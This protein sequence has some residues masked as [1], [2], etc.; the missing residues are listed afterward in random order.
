M[1]VL[2]LALAALG[3]CEGSSGEPLPEP[4][5]GSQVKVD[6]VGY[7]PNAAKLAVVSGELAEDGFRL[8]DQATGKTVLKGKLS[9]SA[10]DNASGDRVRTADFS[11]WT[12]PGTYVI[13]ANSG[14]SSHPF[15]IGA[16]VYRKLWTDNGRSFTLHRAGAA[17]DDPV[18]GLAHAA[19]HVQDQAAYMFTGDEFHPQDSQL[20]VS[21]GWYDAGDYGKYTPTAAVST[22]N[23]LLAY[24]WNPD[25]FA[26]GQWRIPEALVASG[27]AG[28]L[29][30]VLQEAKV[31]LDWLLKMQRPDGAVYL[32]VA[33]RQW[34][35][36]VKPE[37]D[38]SDRYVFGLSTYGTGQFAGVTA[39]AARVYQP[40]NA[41]YAA[42]LLAHA[43]LAQQYLLAHPEPQFQLAEGQDQG[44]GPYRKDTDQE[45]RFWATAELLRTTGAADYAKQLQ[46]S[47]AKL[48]GATPQDASW[49]NTMLWGQWA[50]ANSPQAEAGLRE[51]AK[52][53]IGAF[54]QQLLHTVQQDGYRAALRADEYGWGS[55]R[56]LAA[57]AQALLMAAALQP[58]AALEEAAASQLHYLLGAN[59]LG[60]SFVTGAGAVPP[61]H[62]HSRIMASTGTYVPGVLVGGPNRDGGDAVVN[63]LMKNAAVP[64]PPAK[65]YADDVESFS[66][67]EYAIDYSSALFF[68][69]S[70]VQP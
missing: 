62:P 69:L 24:E 23:L 49:M 31:E 47:F 52:A 40:F 43:K 27:W 11:K 50:L 64:L 34:P 3:G 1:S 41:A 29:P 16:D 12:Q 22:A 32:K 55:N 58:D 38:V 57:K 45:E 18:S 44:S 25:K 6:Q 14:G 59:A 37:E 51:Q 10:E 21:G 61:L 66:T 39:L 17:M 33:G 8:V 36:Y 68:L 60:R 67:N 19:G 4:P 54:G 9:K 35:G 15:A 42:E 56:A 7:L 70:H 13:K 53:A 5:A 30:D 46:S 2:A 48:A 26:A 63:T 20:D 65:V 28:S